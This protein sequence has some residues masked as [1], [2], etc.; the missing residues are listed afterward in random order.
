MYLHAVFQYV[1]IA[2]WILY[3]IPHGFRSLWRIDLWLVGT[4]TYT[5]CIVDSVIQASDISHVVIMKMGEE[6]SLELIGQ[7]GVL[8]IFG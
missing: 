7:I 3:C 2:E 4:K 8:K 1:G 6:Y 5:Q